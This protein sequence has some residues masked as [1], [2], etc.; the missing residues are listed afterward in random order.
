MH[1]THQTDLAAVL[2]SSPVVHEIRHRCHLQHRR[3]VLDVMSSYVVYSQPASGYAGG[4]H[5]V[6]FFVFHGGDIGPGVM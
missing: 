5:T 3:S 2:E 4:S 6:Q 1:Q